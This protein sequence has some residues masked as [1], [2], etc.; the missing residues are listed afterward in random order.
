VSDSEV[1][2]RARLWAFEAMRFFARAANGNEQL[3]FLTLAFEAALEA[4]RAD[5]L[6]QQVVDAKEAL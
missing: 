4:G 5:G 1:D 3:D 2:Q 6:A